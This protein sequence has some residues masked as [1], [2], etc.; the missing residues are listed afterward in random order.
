MRQRGLQQ[1]DGIRRHAFG[2][3]RSFSFGVGDWLRPMLT[4]VAMRDCDFY[5]RS[6]NL[7]YKDSIWGW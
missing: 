7:K 1:G 3:R 6:N 2:V 4:A 5:A